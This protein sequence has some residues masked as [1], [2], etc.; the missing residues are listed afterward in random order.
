MYAMKSKLTVFI[1]KVFEVFESRNADTDRAVSFLLFTRRLLKLLP[2]IL[3]NKSASDL[4]SDLNPDSIESAI[5]LLLDPDL[6]GNK[7]KVPV[8]FKDYKQYL[9]STSILCCGSGS[10]MIFF[11]I[12]DLGS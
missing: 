7:N 8:L 10:G 9:K 3:P 12:P 11:R 5:S 1:C 4:N 6:A 2:I